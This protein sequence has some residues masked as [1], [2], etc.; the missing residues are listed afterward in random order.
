MAKVRGTSNAPMILG[1]IGGVL[2]IPGSICSGAC[3]AGLTSLSEGATTEVTNAAGNTF[4]IIGLIGSILG[5][6]F[7][8][9]AKKMPIPAGILMLVATVLVGITLVTFSFL[10]LAVVILFLIGAIISFTQKKETIE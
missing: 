7:G 6:V 4:M 2:G 1:I 5:L 10:N 3:A 9:L 8:I